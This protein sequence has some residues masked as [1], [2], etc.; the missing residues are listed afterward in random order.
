MLKSRQILTL[1]VRCNNVN[2][3]SLQRFNSPSSKRM[4]EFDQHPARAF[5]LIQL[6]P[7]VH[8]VALGNVPGPEDHARDATSGKNLGITEIINP[9]RLGLPDAAHEL[10]DQR[11][12]WNGLQRRR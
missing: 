1:C 5:K 7:L 12:F 8:R 2:S 10:L 11:K 3:S 6:N 4:Q 9:L